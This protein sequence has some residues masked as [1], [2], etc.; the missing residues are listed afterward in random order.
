VLVVAYFPRNALFIYWMVVCGAA[1]AMIDALLWLRWSWRFARAV[2]SFC[3]RRD[4]MVTVA[5][6]PDIPQ[7]PLES[8]IKHMQHSLDVFTAGFGFPLGA[9]RPLIVPDTLFTSRRRDV[10]L[11]IFRDPVQFARLA[12]IAGR[13]AT[14]AQECSVDGTVLEAANVIVIF[15]SQDQQLSVI[16]R[17]ELAH[18]FALS[19]NRMAPPL[20]SEGLATYLEVDRDDCFPTEIAERSDG[21]YRQIGVARLLNDF[22]NEHQASH[23]YR[24]AQLFVASLI[25]DFGWAKFRTFYQKATDK[26]FSTVFRKVYAMPLDEC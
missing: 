15:C 17:H 3:V 20:L 14:S 16:A 23:N 6:A 5:S 7:E 25:H 8:L 18:L 13:D 21:S 12:G 22:Y 1:I 24:L 11:Y 19:I 26:N 9:A 2:H 4:G 10:I